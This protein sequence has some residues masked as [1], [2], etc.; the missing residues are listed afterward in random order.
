MDRWLAQERTLKVLAV[1]L[2]AA[3]WLLVS[4]ETE[5]AERPFDNV[6]VTVVGLRPDLALT[7][8]DAQPHVRVTVRGNPNALSRLLADDLR[9]VVDLSDAGPGTAQPRVEVTVP[10]GVQ[11]V[12][13]SPAALSFRLEQR[14]T[15]QVPVFVQTGGQVPE[16]FRQEE[17]LLGQREVQI[18]GPR[19]QVEKVSY[20]FGLVDVTGAAEDVTRNVSLTPIS[21]DGQEVPTVLV[22]PS[23]IEVTVPIRRLPPAA[24]RDI[25]ARLSG[26]PAPGYRVLSVQVLP[27]QVQV[28]GPANRLAVL[29]GVETEAVD[30]DGAR[31]TVREEVGLIMPDGINEV[32][33]A[34][35]TV[36]VEIVPDQLVRT[37]PSVPLD[38]RGQPPEH[39]TVTERTVTVVVAGLSH[40]I[41]NLDTGTI[42]AFIDVSGLEEGEHT[43]PVQADLPSGLQLRS[44][45]PVSVQVTITVPVE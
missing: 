14:I 9:A 7:D 23:E 20:V 16:E 36:I 1:I 31:T 2:A 3:L 38:V 44:L 29:E 17:P 5:S 28:R 24:T 12:S 19:S 13:V 15:R 39:V 11:V 33:P 18:E 43:V 42:V 40:I 8:G 45:D 21:R 22:A 6:P 34:R 4:F 25:E 10:R 41:N 35:V 27:E 37:I 30:I 32:K 26:A